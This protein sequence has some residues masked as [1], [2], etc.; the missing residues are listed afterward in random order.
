MECFLTFSN[1]TGFDRWPPVTL[2]KWPWNELPPSVRVDALGLVAGRPAIRF[3][4][5][6]DRGRVRDWCLTRGLS[7]AQDE[8]FIVISTTDADS[9]LE[10]DRSS[11]PHVLELGLM[12]GYPRCCASLAERAG[13]GCIDLLA[14][15]SSDWYLPG[16]W[17]LT[18]TSGYHHGSAFLSHVPCSSRCQASLALARRSVNTVAMYSTRRDVEPFLTWRRTLDRLSPA[19]PRAA[20]SRPLR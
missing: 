5:D 20:C 3:P 13:E 10:V 1:S 6:G 9:V 14:I 11:R 2:D 18:D 16:E 12:L 15:R 8:E 19:P 17:K 4:M 7:F